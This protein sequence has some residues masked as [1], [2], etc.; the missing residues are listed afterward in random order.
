MPRLRLGALL[1]AGALAGPLAPGPAAAQ[2]PRGLRTGPA[3]V[4]YAGV[5]V[6]GTTL[7]QDDD[8]DGGWDARAGL[9]YGARLEVPL[10]SRLGVQGDVGYATSRVVGFGPG[11]EDFEV[12]GHF[13]ALT[14]RLAWRVTSPRS[15]VAFS[16]HGGGGLMRHWVSSPNPTHSTW[17]TAVAGAITRVRVTP[18]IELALGAETYLYTAKFEGE[19]PRSRGQ[20]DY[21]FTVGVWLPVN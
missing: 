18:R 5:H 19:E 13:L 21:R 3:F 1:L 4:P 12:D 20:R 7:L 15:P 8:L 11:Y 14:A 9:V 10:G 6:P 17:P 2:A 16:V